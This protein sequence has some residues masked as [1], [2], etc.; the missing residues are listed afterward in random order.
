LFSPV[1]GRFE[2]PNMG[3]PIFGSQYLVS[4]SIWVIQNG[5]KENWKPERMKAAIKAM[6]NK[7]M[8]SYKASRVFTLPQ[9]TRLAENLK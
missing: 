9:T 6:R 4:Y 7:E 8:G 5:S 1:T 3:L 2:E